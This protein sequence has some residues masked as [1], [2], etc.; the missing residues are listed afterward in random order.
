M[1][2]Q[3]VLPQNFTFRS[4]KS[5]VYLN[6]N[7]SI[8]SNQY[9]EGVSPMRPLCALILLAPVL[10]EQSGSTFKVRKAADSSKM[11]VTI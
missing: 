7:V 4:P 2:A 10:E 8:I 5:P 11:L 9:Y 3:N 1:C 6:S